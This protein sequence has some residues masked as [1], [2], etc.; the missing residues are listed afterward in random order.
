[1]RS[2]LLLY[3]RQRIS[4][5]LMLRC[6]QINHTISFEF[7]CLSFLDLS[8]LS[9]DISKRPAWRR[10]LPPRVFA[11]RFWLLICIDKMIS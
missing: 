10:A 8:V 11:R 5:L 6:S 4:V 2:Y 3:R 1:M 7:Q 9:I